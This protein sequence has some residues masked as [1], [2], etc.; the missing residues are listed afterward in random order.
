MR[1]WRWVVGTFIFI[2]ILD[3]VI[4]MGKWA[5]GRYT[6]AGILL[7][8][9]VLLTGSAALALVF[10]FIHRWR[11]RLERQYEQY[12]HHGALVWVRK[13]LKGKHWDPTMCL[14]CCRFFPHTEH[15][16]ILAE[17]LFQV[18]QDWHIVIAVWECPQF[19]EGKCDELLQPTNV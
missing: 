16:C 7:S 1:A 3:S 2:V 17:R 8:Y 6:E 11:R 14:D 18:C 13:D 9:V 5:V 15:N 10:E 4:D 19:D 12:D